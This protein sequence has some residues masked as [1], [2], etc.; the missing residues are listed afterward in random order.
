MKSLLTS[1]ILVLILALGGQ[2]QKYITKNGYIRFY[3]DAP[4]EKIEATNRQ[5]N[6]ALDTQT[7][8][9]VFKVLMKSFL[10]QN[11]TMQDHFNQKYVE[12]D[13][14]PN[15]TFVGK[16]TNLKEVTFAKEGTY[17]ALVEGKLTIHG[18]T[19]D[20]KIPGTFEVKNDVILGKAVFNVAVKDFNIS[21][22]TDVVSKIADTIQVTVDVVVEKLTK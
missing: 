18:V 2:A 15:A 8:D 3:S 21:I 16:V 12:S 20:V 4:L 1:L 17:Q 9:F 5:V 22:P 11:A 19:R 14:Y 10:F 6:A 13:K 7:G